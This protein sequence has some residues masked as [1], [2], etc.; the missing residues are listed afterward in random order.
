M[1]FALLTLFIAVSISAV[2]AYYSI[3]GLMAIFAAAKIPIAIMGGVL[4]VGKL[5]V[6]SWTFRNWKTSPMIM[7]IYF[8][9]A[10]VVL[11]LI[12]SLGIF[13]FLSRAHL[14]QANPTALL[15]QRIERI[16]IKMNQKQEQITRLEDSVNAFDS[17][18]MKY[19]DLGA[20]TKGLQAREQQQEQLSSLKNQILTIEREIDILNDEKFEL[21]SE[22]RL[23]EVEVGPIRYVASLVYDD[24]NNDQLESAVRW[25]IILLILVFDPLAVVLVIAGNISLQQVRL[26]REKEK[27]RNEKN[28]KKSISLPGNRKAIDTANIHEFSEDG[29]SSH[30]NFKFLSWSAFN[31]MKKGERNK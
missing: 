7:K 17:A 8:V 26:D 9:I 15:K 29:T 13:G 24:V 16:D 3:I 22:I 25:I 27:R 11:M 14:E 12:T 31:K 2:A 6:A 18:F 19:L 1:I 20:V 30:S 10:I 28:R 23:S 21:N 4:E 5:I